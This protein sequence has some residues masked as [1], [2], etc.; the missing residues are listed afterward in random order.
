MPRVICE[1]QTPEPH[2]R[3]G[4]VDFAVGQFLNAQGVIVEVNLLGFRKMPLHCLS[5][6]GTTSRSNGD[7]RL[8]EIGNRLGTFLLGKL[9]KSLQLPES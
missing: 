4:R 2:R 7:V 9:I 5:T 6:G 8:V 3:R 1:T